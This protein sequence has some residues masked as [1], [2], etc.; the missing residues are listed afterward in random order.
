MIKLKDQLAYSTRKITQPEK[1]FWPE[2]E[3]YRVMSA[4]AVL[5][6]NNERRIQLDLDKP[7]NKSTLDSFSVS[8]TTS[9]FPSAISY[10]IMNK[11]VPDETNVILR[12]APTSNITQD[13]ILYPE[14]ISETAKQQAGNTIKSLKSQNLIQ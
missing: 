1:D 14:Y 9:A 11:H 3:E 8:S 4:Q 10:F 7:L 5:D 12:Y 2:S 13:G 6:N